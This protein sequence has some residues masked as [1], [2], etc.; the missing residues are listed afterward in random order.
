[1]GSIE[2][3]LVAP[4]GNSSNLQVAQICKTE[5]KNNQPVV[6][7]IPPCLPNLSQGITETLVDQ[8][9]PQY[10]NH[11][12]ARNGINLDELAC[13]RKETAQR[14]IASNKRYKAGLHVAAGRYLLGPEVIND[15]LKRKRHGE[16]VQNE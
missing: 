6:S 1:L 2:Q 7:Y 4:S 10:R 3:Q 12:D 14:A 9:I 8:V 16:E 13:Q 11:E 15:Q 5:A